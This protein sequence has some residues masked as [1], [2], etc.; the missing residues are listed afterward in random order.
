MGQIIQSALSDA[1]PVFM[2]RK[3]VYLVMALVPLAAGFYMTTLP[4]AVTVNGAPQVYDPR[5]GFAID[6]AFGWG[7]VAYWFALPA[8]VRT[9][10]P[11]FRLTVG[12]FF[13]LIGLTLVVGIVCGIASILVIPGIWIGV[14]WTQIIWC[15]VFGEQPNPFGASWRIT[16][17]QFWETFGFLLLVGLVAVLPILAALILIWLV[18]ASPFLGFILLP[19]AFLIY[20][21]ALNFQLLAG[22]RWFLQLRERAAGGGRAVTAYS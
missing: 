7:G 2:S 12:Q 6:A 19:I 3:F 9:A 13:G 15:Y 21:F 11:D 8:V 4:P 14:K 16:T 20:V 22:M 1:W 18:N 5:L 10:E 17:G